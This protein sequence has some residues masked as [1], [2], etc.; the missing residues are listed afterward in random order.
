[1]GILGPRFCLE[2]RLWSPQ[3]RGVGVRADDSASWC[4]AYKQLK[5]CLDPLPLYFFLVGTLY[6]LER[7]RTSWLAAGQLHLR[8]GHPRPSLRSPASSQGCLGFS[9]RVCSPG[10]ASRPFLHG[11]RFPRLSQDSKPRCLGVKKV[12]AH[13]VS[14]EQQGPA[15]GSTLPKTALPGERP[16]HL[17]LRFDLLPILMVS[18][19]ILTQK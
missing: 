2:G 11:Q 7:A 8:P 12:K 3:S 9:Q 6:N 1:M 5:I 10:L 19:Y 14:L 15:A 17:N 13:I 16:G 18:L 4:R